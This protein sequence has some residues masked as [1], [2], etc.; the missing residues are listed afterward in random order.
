MLE[1]QLHTGVKGFRLQ[2]RFQETYS[3]PRTAPISE[4][5]VSHLTN[6][7]KVWLLVSPS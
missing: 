4:L 2:V 5:K 1:G 7:L 3:L 6:S